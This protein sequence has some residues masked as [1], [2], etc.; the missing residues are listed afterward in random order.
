MEL[1]TSQSGR[2]TILKARI[3]GEDAD[4]ARMESNA[5]DVDDAKGIFRDAGVIDPPYDLLELAELYEKS[6][7]LRPNVESYANNID[8]NSHHYKPVVN[9]DSDDAHERIFDALYLERVLAK[10][11]GEPISK[12]DPTEKEVE[13][14]LIEI[15]R[16]MRV[17]KSRLDCF[18]ESCTVDESFVS[19]R[20]RTRTTLES[21]GNAYWEVIR[22]ERT[23]K[24]SQFVFLPVH[25][26]RLLPL[27]TDRVEVDLPIRTTPITISTEKVKRRFRRF[28]QVIDRRTTW[29]K[30][31]GDPRIMSA[32]TGKFFSSPEALKAA[33]PTATEATEVYHFKLHSSLSVYG[34]PRWI[35]NLF[36]V[37][38]SIKADEVN[39]LYFDNKA[40]PPLALL[41]SGGTVTEQ[42]VERIEDYIEENLKGSANFHKILVIEGESAPSQDGTQNTGKLKLELKPLTSAQLSD[43][44]F[45][46]YDERNMDKAGMAYRL[47]RL[48]R[49][50]VRDFNRS[51]ADAALE[52][53][54]SQVF[55]QERNDFDRMIDRMVL[56]SLGITLWSFQSNSVSI[57]DP[58]VM[59][60]VI[61]KLTEANVLVP[62]DAREL[63][64]ELVFNRDLR[65]IDADW[66]YQPVMLTQVGVP[67]D[68]KLDGEIPVAAQPEGAAGGGT[69]PAP[70]AGSK[71]PKLRAVKGRGVA[72]LAGMNHSEMVTNARALVRFQKALLAAEEEA[73][74]DEFKKAKAAE[75]EPEQAQVIK[76]P[77]AEMKARFALGE[78]TGKPAGGP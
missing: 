48:L 62:A 63:A 16:T 29:F 69:Q 46:K 18:F 64:G 68:A 52:F 44:I 8:G 61:A 73:A 56:W 58:K 4:D 33:E 77:H 27:G 24:V 15:G 38:G 51:T 65:K 71:G 2:T 10:E 20:R 43:G 3:L 6:G 17:E 78:P 14:K 1:L 9:V 32:N 72:Q 31:F 12:L 22:R 42:S 45:Q 35:G 36:G 66:A 67:A 19:L 55:S 53:T 23:R 25:T 75:G 50:D 74:D 5:A 11:A 7:I 34:V 57:S 40:V 37:A 47:P 76:M 41:V 59:A 26:M 54:E 70:A 60:E 28:I 30:E 39:Y 49:G 21:T 13:D